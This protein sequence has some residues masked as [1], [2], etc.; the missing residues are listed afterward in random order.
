VRSGARH[1]PLTCSAFATP[2]AAPELDRLTGL[3]SLLV[4]PSLAL[5]APYSL[6]HTAESPARP[7]FNERVVDVRAV[8]QEHIGKSAIVLILAVGLKD[9]ISPE[10]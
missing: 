3:S 10:D 4:R 8:R 5:P 2:T 9:D 6:A 7:V 1:A